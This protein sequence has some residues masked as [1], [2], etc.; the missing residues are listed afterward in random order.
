MLADLD[1]ALREPDGVLVEKDADLEETIGPGVRTA[2]S[3]QAADLRGMGGSPMSSGERHGQAA[4]ATGAKRIIVS[5][6]KGQG[7]MG[8]LTWAAAIAIVGVTLGIVLHRTAAAPKPGAPGPAS[9]AGK[10]PIPSLHD[11]AKAE[12]TIKKL[13]AGEYSDRTNTAREALAK[14]LLEQGAATADDMS[15]RYVSYREARDLAASAGDM[16]LAMA[17]IDAMDKDFVIDASDLRATAFATAAP[18]ASPDA[19]LATIDTGLALLEPVVASE[20]FVASHKILAA[21]ETAVSKSKQLPLVTKVQAR[22][23][24]VMELQRYS[25]HLRAARETLKKDPDNPAA[26][27]TVGQHLAMKKDDWDAALSFL[28]K[29]SDASL[30]DLASKEL[31]KPANAKAQLQLAI[32]WWDLAEKQPGPAKTSFQAHAR[33]LYRRA[34]PGLAAADTALV[35]GRLGLKDG[36]VADGTDRG[37]STHSLIKNGSFTDGKDTPDE[38]KFADGLKGKLTMTRDTTD[39]AVGPASLRVSIDKEHSFGAVVQSFD[40]PAEGTLRISGHFKTSID[41][42]GMCQ[43][44]RSR[45]ARRWSSFRP[46]SPSRFTSGVNTRRRTSIACP[47]FQLNPS[48]R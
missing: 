15:V 25:G 28:A 43:S 11:Q 13:F 18:L 12:Q 21:L 10:Q 17:A 23:A 24:E 4:R 35:A 38:W 2:M 22:Q 1:A 47:R 14:K 6:L 26:N 46:I 37:A 45:N 19:G 20:N 41:F 36:Y 5:I 16:K 39:F 34:F 33:V 9:I 40:A 31:A 3:G 29:C 30:K 27:L 44:H 42:N 8:K 48:F 32:G 7:L